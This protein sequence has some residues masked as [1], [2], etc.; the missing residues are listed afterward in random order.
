MQHDVD[1]AD[2]PMKSAIVQQMKTAHHVPSRIIMVT[3]GHV[4]YRIRLQRAQPSRLPTA[5]P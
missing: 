5:I 2:S 3:S 4:L 1:P